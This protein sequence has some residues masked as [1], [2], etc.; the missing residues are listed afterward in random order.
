MLKLKGRA[1]LGWLLQVVASSCWVA[2]VF[3][4]DNLDKPG[5]RL[6]LVAAIAWSVSNLLM[7]PDLFQQ[8]VDTAGEPATLQQA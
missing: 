5:D 6:Q 7:V 1:A 4:Y 3:V 8:Q 2:S